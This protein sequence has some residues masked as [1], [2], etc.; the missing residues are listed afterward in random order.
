MNEGDNK[1]HEHHGGYHHHHQDQESQMHAWEMHQQALNYQYARMSPTD[2]PPHAQYGG[3]VH[4]HHHMM[5]GGAASGAAAAAAAPGQHNPA[6]MNPGSA[7]A[8]GGGGEAGSYMH[9]HPAQMMHHPSYAAYAPQQQQQHEQQQQSHHHA[10]N[11]YAHPHS[12][13]S[14]AYY[15]QHYHHPHMPQ[16]SRNSP[17][18]MEGE[19]D[20]NDPRQAPQPYYTY[21]AYAHHPSDPQA[22]YGMMH[23]PMQEH[24]H[25]HHPHGSETSKAQHSHSHH[26]RVSYDH[27]VQPSSLVSASTDPDYLSSSSAIHPSSSAE[28]QISL[29]SAVKTNPSD[30]ATIASTE[31]PSPSGAPPLPFT[32]SGTLSTTSDRNRTPESTGAPSRESIEE[33]RSHS[34]AASME[35]ISGSSE[36]KQTLDTASVLLAFSST[37]KPRPSSE[38]SMMDDNDSKGSF[39]TLPTEPSFSSMIS[40]PPNEHFVVPSEYPRRLKTLEDEEKLNALHC[41]MRSDLLEIVVIQPVTGSDKSE[42]ITSDS[43]N[44]PTSTDPQMIGR[45]GLRCVFCAMSPDGGRVG[46][47]MS[48]FYPRTVSEIYRL[49]TS[50]KRCHL[51]KCRHLPPN[52]RQTLDS[53][54]DCRARGKTAYWIDSAHAIGLVDIPTKIG[55]VRFQTDSTGKIRKGTVTRASSA[56]A[57]SVQSTESK[58]E[59]KDLSSQE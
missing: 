54:R 10:G 24:H 42:R 51:S 9:Y 49:V 50:W 25:R 52:V 57:A 46:P 43:R 15:P 47:S 40:E 55:G 12:H 17:H 38:T 45:V 3:S 28:H 27:T 13:S 26:S 31:A 36:K 58:P 48:I 37:K 32:Q 20:K 22:G 4:H 33:H 39:P 34:K 5:H 23:P 44:T 8:S 30:D 1:A 14:A 53:F 18:S 59:D 7:A 35:P 19:Y 41:F 11:Y 6:M 29:T 21:G 56:Q 2:V 16:Y